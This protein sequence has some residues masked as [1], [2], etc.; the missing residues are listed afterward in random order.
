M[1]KASKMLS[2]DREEMSSFERSLFLKDLKRVAEEY[3]ECDGEASME[4]TR[5]EDGFL[6][7]VIFP[8]RRVKGVK[9]VLK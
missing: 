5:T 4:M 3:F 2:L 9:P 7:C 1:R 6:V 8:A